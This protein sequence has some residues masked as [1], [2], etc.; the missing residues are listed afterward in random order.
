MSDLCKCGAPHDGWPGNDG[1]EL[2]QMC[3]EAEC[4][5]SWWEMVRRFP[6]A[7]RGDGGQRCRPER[8]TVSLGPYSVQDDRVRLGAKETRT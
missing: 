6:G 5:E 2:C 3:W 4:S 8:G 1:D 7:A